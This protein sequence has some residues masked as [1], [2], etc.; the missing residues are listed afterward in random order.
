[1]SLD[2]W[3]DDPDDLNADDLDADEPVTVACPVCGA[4]MYEDSPRCPVCE[5]YVTPSTSRWHG[6][7]VWWVVLGLAGVVAFLYL[8][9]VF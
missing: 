4:E 7:P 6:K 3:D 5:S 9:V 2:D 1:M 8:L